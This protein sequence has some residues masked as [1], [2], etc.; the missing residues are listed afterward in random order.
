[1]DA[2][3]GQEDEAM[4]RPLD[5][6]R[7]LDMSRIFAAPFT[8]QIL[9]DLGA[10]VIKVERP[11]GGDDTRSWG[12]PFV[13]N[14]QGVETAETGY[15]QALNRGKK[16][17]TVDISHPEGQALVRALIERS[18]VLIENFRPGTLERYGLGWEN[19]RAA[20]P[21][22]VHCSVTGFGQDGPYRDRPAKS[23]RCRR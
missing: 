21:R 20:N 17:V 14:A 3:A 16:S 11:G 6:T 7:V 23:R 2:N 10:E 19:L 13:R 12:P 5:G 15:F 4:T 8:G 9:A 18:D 22:L 1:M